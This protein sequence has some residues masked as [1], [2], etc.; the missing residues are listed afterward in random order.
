MENDQILERAVEKM[1]LAGHR[2]GLDV[3]DL[4]NLLN[5]GMSV[6]QLLQYLATKLAERPVEN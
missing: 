2:A 5:E 4:I 1:I 6:E 3:S